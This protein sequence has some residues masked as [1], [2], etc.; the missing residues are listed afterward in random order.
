MKLNSHVA[1]YITEVNQALVNEN[2]AVL[3]KTDPTAKRIRDEIKQLRAKHLDGLSAAN[4]DEKLS[5]APV[6]TVAWLASLNAYSKIREHMR[7]IAEAI[8]EVK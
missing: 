7:E 1:G 8:A 2:K 5:V 4:A 6:I 3:T